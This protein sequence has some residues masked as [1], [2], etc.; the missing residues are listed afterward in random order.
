MSGIFTIL[1]FMLLGRTSAVEVDEIKSA[2]SQ[3]VYSRLDS[4]MQ[5]N[6]I[7]EFRGGLER[8]PFRETNMNCM[9]GWGKREHARHCLS[10]C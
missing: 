7:I 9:L 1:A 4:A 5:K 6:A 8:V 3:Y 10:S 2:V